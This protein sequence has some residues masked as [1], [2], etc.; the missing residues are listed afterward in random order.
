MHAFLDVSGISNTL[1]LENRP[2]IKNILQNKT[3]KQREQ[4]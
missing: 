4:F 3:E 2:L 1:A